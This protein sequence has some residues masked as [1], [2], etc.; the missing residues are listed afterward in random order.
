MQ[1]TPAD[2]VVLEYLGQ[3]GTNS[4][5]IFSSFS[6]IFPYYF[7]NHRKKKSKIDVTLLKKV[8]ND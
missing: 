7:L 3:N 4:I 5:F 8:K 6:V 1:S 2:D